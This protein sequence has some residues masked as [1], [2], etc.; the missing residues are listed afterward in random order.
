MKRA[1]YARII[2]AVF[3]LLFLFGCIYDQVAWLANGDLIFVSFVKDPKTDKGRR[4]EGEFVVMRASDLSHSVKRVEGLPDKVLRVALSPDGDRI[5]A[6]TDDEI[7]LARL[8]GSAAI[9]ESILPQGKLQPAGNPFSPDGHKVAYMVTEEV[10]VPAG[11]GPVQTLAIPHIML[12]D[13]DTATT[14]MLTSGVRATVFPVWSP[15][16]RQIA[17]Y[18]GEPDEEGDYSTIAFDVYCLDLAT[19][20]DE[21]LLSKLQLPAEVAGDDIDRDGINFT[22]PTWSP[23]SD[24]LYVP[25]SGGYLRISLN[26]NSQVLLKPDLR[27]PCSDKM[28]GVIF[29]LRF[30]PFGGEAVFCGL[31]KPED[32]DEKNRKE[33]GKLGLDLWRA[34]A[35]LTDARRITKFPG[36]EYAPA[37]SPNGDRIAFMYG[38]EG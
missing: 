19:G 1:K 33:Y 8:E 11:E 30:S 27:D 24:A 21:K 37:W 14:S 23:D 20:K 32:R 12:Y 15:N 16:G 9:Y 4:G 25:Q 35:D 36:D 3:P 17:F 22:L 5:L 34:N 13:R 7:I 10:E 18:A 38:W 29:W 26:D 2:L 6:S 31:P 28:P